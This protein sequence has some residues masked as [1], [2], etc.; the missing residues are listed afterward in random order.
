MTDPADNQPHDAFHDTIGHVVPLRLLAG[1]FAA[2]IFL[3]FVTVG[4]TYV[5]FG[6]NPNLIIAILIAVVKASLVALYFMHLRWDSPFNSMVLVASFVFV[7]LIIIFALV[8]SF[9]YAPNVIDAPDPA[10]ISPG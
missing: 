7:A 9:N 8:D 2:L 3:T 4:V 6:R 1:I 5:D 10:A